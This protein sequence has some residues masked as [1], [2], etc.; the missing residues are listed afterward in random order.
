MG[1][2][3]HPVRPVVARFQ[4]RGSIPAGGGADGPAWRA[5]RHAGPNRQT[6]RTTA[7]WAGSGPVSTPGCAGIR[8][9]YRKQGTR[10]VRSYARAGG[11]PGPLRPAHVWAG[12]SFGTAAG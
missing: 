11:S 7:S 3:A 10:R 1:P 12:M 2:V 6:V 4:G 8:L 5:P 9:A